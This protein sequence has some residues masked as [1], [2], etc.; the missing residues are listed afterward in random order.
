MANKA[1]AIK[2]LRQSQKRRMRNKPIRTY[3]RSSV[4]AA[5]DAIDDALDTQEWNDADTAIQQAV[6][7][8]DRAAQRGVI[9]ANTAARKKS[10][11]LRQY[12]VSR[13]PDDVRRPRMRPPAPAQTP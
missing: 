3:A 8:L 12:H 5:L 7:A 10:R 9:H 6:S 4:R 11:L 2:Y 1:A 13:N